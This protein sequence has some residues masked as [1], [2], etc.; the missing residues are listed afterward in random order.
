MVIFLFRIPHTEYELL[1]SSTNAKAKS[2]S[3][4]L[5][6]STTRLQHPQITP[7][8]PHAKSNGKTNSNGIG[9]SNSGS[10]A[11]GVHFFSMCLNGATVAAGEGRRSDLEA[12]KKV[13][14]WGRLWNS[15]PKK[16]TQKHSSLFFFFWKSHED[17]K[18]NDYYFLTMA[19]RRS[20]EGRQ[21]G[22]ERTEWCTTDVL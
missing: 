13:N 20:C 16:L 9:Q 14:D 12:Q 6:G 3:Q 22:Y 21:D 5:L 18:L 15:K 19:K 4:S 8:D 10:N 11:N 7:S 17:Q 1:S 2:F